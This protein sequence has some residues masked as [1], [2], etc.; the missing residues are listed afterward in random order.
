MSCSAAPVAH[1]CEADDG[2]KGPPLETYEGG[3]GSSNGG[4]S[5]GCS[6]MGLSQGPPVLRPDPQGLTDEA[7]EDA[8]EFV[9]LQQHNKMLTTLFNDGCKKLNLG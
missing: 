4:P 5:F 1:Y 3:A 9:Q 6:S 8:I 2:P 7:L